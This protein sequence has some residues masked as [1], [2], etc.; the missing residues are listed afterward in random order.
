MVD[1]PL[2][3]WLLAAVL[4][5][6]ACGPGPYDDHPGDSRFLDRACASG[7][8]T[9]K[10][11][12]QRVS[13]PTSDTIAFLLDGAA[14]SPSGSAVTIPL[15]GVTI[16]PEDNLCSVELLVSGSGTF[17][18]TSGLAFDAPRDFAWVRVTNDCSSPIVV[19]VEDRS[20]L[21]IDDV[22]VVTT[23]SQSG[24]SAGYPD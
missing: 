24:C 10:G 16:P 23:R 3:R 14:S 21:L 1:R 6:L 7:A 5:P 22:R 17:G 9:T 8:C 20:T 15:D 12:V 13:G 4:A 19:A 11:D 2:S 18:V